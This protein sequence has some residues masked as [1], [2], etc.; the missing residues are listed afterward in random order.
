ME[1][2]QKNTSANRTIFLDYIP[3]DLKE[4]SGENWRI[5]FSVKI[6][7]QEKFKRFKRRVP[8]H[9]N[10][11]VRK[12]IATRMSNNI[13]RKL[14]SG[15]SPFFDGVGVNEFKTLQSVFETYLKQA[16]RK[17][18]DKLLRKD[19]FRAYASF[20][21]NI[22]QY[23]QEKDLKNMFVVEFN[24]KFVLE[25]LDY[26][27][28]ERKRTARTHNN[29]LLFLNQLAIFMNERNFIPSNPVTGIAK[30][31]VSKKKR[32]IIPAEV[33]NE[34]FKYQATNNTNYLCL[35][36]TV[37][38]CFIRRTEISKLKVKH[39]NLSSNSIFIPAEISKNKKDG[40]VTIPKMLKK[41]FIKH[42]EKSTEE[43]WLFSSDHFKPGT[44]KINP[45]KIS[46]EWAKMRSELNFKDSYQ[47]YSLKDSGITQLFYLNVPLIKI[48]DQARHHDI[49]ITETYTPRNHK[50][51]EFLVD[52][53]FNF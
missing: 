49:K 42:L 3:A 41:I 1:N 52:L 13:N 2:P 12:K 7:G 5:V 19:T 43:D 27:Y 23:L 45:K 47:F 38:F 8:K 30:K 25:F 14:E 33:K 48:R 17:V 20:I 21:S 31:V 22:Q 24:R 26:I 46:S 29:Y 39:V 53:D 34:I 32:E 4:T 16:Q 51:D 37:Y 40:V 44:R 10:K 28:Y 36:L 15:W 18:D 6:P 9:S 35:C 11:T 50:A